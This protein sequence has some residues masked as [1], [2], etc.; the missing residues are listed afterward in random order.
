MKRKLGPWS[1]T[2]DA[3]SF[4]LLFF[5]NYYHCLTPSEKGEVLTEP[6]AIKREKRSSS[7]DQEN[8]PS[9]GDPKSLSQDE[10]VYFLCDFGISMAATPGMWIR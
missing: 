8:E 9:L 4:L 2:H 6:I 7:K 10:H 3:E 5:Y 1:K